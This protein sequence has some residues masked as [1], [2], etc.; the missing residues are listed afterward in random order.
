[1][2]GLHGREAVFQAIHLPFVICLTIDTTTF[3]AFNEIQESC[4][5][6]IMLCRNKNGKLRLKY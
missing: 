1:M 5:G 3:F 4:V 6:Y 2:V